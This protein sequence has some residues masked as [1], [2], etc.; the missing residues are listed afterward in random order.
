[1]SHERSTTIQIK[2][3]WYNF[4]SMIDGKGPY[5]DSHILKLFK[6]GKI[7]PI[8]VHGDMPA[9]VDHAKSRSERYQKPRSAANHDH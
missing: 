9:A 8:S 1:M 2:D 7:K 4:A 5:S 3:K 6:A